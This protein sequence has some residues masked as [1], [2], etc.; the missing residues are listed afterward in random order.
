MLQEGEM[1]DKAE[2]L[3]QVDESQSIKNE[4]T[5][6]VSSL[7]A[8]LEQERS[9]VKVLQAELAKYQGGRKGKRNCEPDQCR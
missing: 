3:L 4:L 6:Q 9:K 5:V 7:H 2:I 8:A 1:K